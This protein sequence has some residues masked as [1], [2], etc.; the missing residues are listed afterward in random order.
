MNTAAAFV[1]PRRREHR[2]G[3]ISRIIVILIDW[4]ERANQR[5]A[6]A[7]L[8]D[9][10]LRDLGLSRADVEIEISKPFWRT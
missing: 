10:A 4:Q 5:H 8:G 9:A 7:S 1:R 2:T 3:F 6:L